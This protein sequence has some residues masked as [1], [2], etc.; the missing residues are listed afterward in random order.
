MNRRMIQPA[1]FGNEL[2][3]AILLSLIVLSFVTAAAGV[4]YPLR[5]RWS[6]P[7]P[8]GGNVVDMGY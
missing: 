6:N 1:N 5:W 7:R 3:Q 8:H 2:S 4:T